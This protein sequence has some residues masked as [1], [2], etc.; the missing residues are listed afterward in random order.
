MSLGNPLRAD[1]AAA[2]DVAAV[3]ALL[4]NALA[5]G[6]AD[7]SAVPVGPADGASVLVA[8]VVAR[9]KAGLELPAHVLG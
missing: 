9:A 3:D 7:P 1:P 2:G 6:S 8:A 4:E 5:P